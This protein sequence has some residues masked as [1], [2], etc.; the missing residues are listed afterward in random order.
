MKMKRIELHA[1]ACTLLA[2]VVFAGCRTSGKSIAGERNVAAA[3]TETTARPIRVNTVE[4][5]PAALADDKQAMIPAALSVNDLA[6][7]LTPHEGRIIEL[8]C[9][10]G[11]RVAKG[12][13]LARL[14]DDERRNQL[15][16]AELDVNRLAIEEKQYEALINL[17]RN[18]LERQR[19]LARDGVVSES[20][21]ERAQYRLDQSAAEYEKTR[22]ATTSARARVDGVRLEIE[23]SVVRAPINGVVTRRYVSLGTGVANGEK[24]F[25][26]SNLSPLEVKFQVPQLDRG[27]LAP[28][29]V[30]ELYSAEG[31]RRLAEARIRRIDSLADATSNTIGCVADVRG[32]AGLLPGLAVNVR[33]PRRPAA[34]SYWIPRA[35]FP[36]SEAVSVG[37]ESQLWVVVEGKCASRAVLVKAVEGDQ[38]EVVSGI[39]AGDRVILAPPAQL[40]E[41]DAVEAQW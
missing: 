24:L 21:V 20:E 11:T 12:A 13:V 30:I 16:L 6:L 37:A 8:H 4:V 35:A 2:L 26:L 25:E 9:D 5:R 31:D 38:V 22:L 29:Q 27:R 34:V 7:V 41:G 3:S 40:K 32:G 18:E 19:R 10:E 17:N 15:R 14:N 28:G 39:A 23:K 33:V 36:A 1:L